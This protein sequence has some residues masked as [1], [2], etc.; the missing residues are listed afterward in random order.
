ML[1]KNLILFFLAF[2]LSNC[3]SDARKLDENLKLFI[4]HEV[5]IHENEMNTEMATNIIEHSSLIFE[6][7]LD[8]GKAA[9]EIKLFMEKEF[10]K[11][12]S[13]LVGRNLTSFRSFQHL[14]GSY[15]RFSV[16]SR[17]V[18]AL[19]SVKILLF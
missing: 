5:V 18:V 11:T 1:A 4:D 17:M 14:S 12:W 6:K 7:V 16:K 10:N 8:D 3:E 9:E 13:V 15:I 2:I 19:K